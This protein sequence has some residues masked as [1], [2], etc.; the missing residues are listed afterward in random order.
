MGALIGGILAR[1]GLAVKHKLRAVVDRER[2]ADAAQSPVG[3]GVL[4]I[5][6]EYAGA[7]IGVAERYGLIGR[8]RHVGRIG[9][10]PRCN[11]GVVIYLP[12]PVIVRIACAAGDIPAAALPAVAG[13]IVKLAQGVI[14]NGVAGQQPLIGVRGFIIA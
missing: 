1:A 4:L 11:A 8:G 9:F 6:R 7:H 2:E 13:G 14:V 12:C 5:K 3:E 10:H